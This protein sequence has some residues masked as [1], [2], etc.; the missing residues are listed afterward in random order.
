MGLANCRRDV[1]PLDDG[2]YLVATRQT[3]KAHYAIHK[4][5]SGTLSVVVEKGRDKWEGVT[6]GNGG[7][8]LLGTLNLGDGDLKQAIVGARA[9][10]GSRGGRGNGRG[11]TL[12]EGDTRGREKSGGDGSELH[13]VGELAYATRCF[14]VLGAGLRWQRTFST[15][16][17][18]LGVAGRDGV[19]KNLMRIGWGK[20]MVM[21][22]CLLIMQ[23]EEK[24]MELWW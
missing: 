2:S 5:P 1:F 7:I 17:T 3:T 16:E 22:A 20:A 9:L 19:W 18:V 6:Y 14:V 8:A 24:E 4:W 13:F 21:M 23:W 15:N 11:D 10:S 12:S